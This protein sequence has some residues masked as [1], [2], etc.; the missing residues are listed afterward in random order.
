MAKLIIYEEAA[1]EDT[2]F[3]DFE[4]LAN[5]ILIG[6]SPDNQLVLDAPDIDP[7]HASLELRL[8]RWILQDLGAPGGTAVNGITIEGPYYLQHNDLI[9][10][11]S[12]KLKFRE[13]EPQGET[14]PERLAPEP[15]HLDSVPPLKGR[16]WFAKVAAG[17]VAV[18]FLILL[19]LIIGHYWGLL[20][21]TD[22]L[23]P[24]LSQMM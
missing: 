20:N 8:D 10:L 15:A 14:E 22:L 21:M 4:L 19:I 23:P 3:E 6:S 24:W 17:T 2:V 16:V 12:I 18:I 13:F 5:R 9:E 1:G 7:A 11:G